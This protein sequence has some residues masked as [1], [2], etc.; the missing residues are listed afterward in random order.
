MQRRQASTLASAEDEIT[1]LKD[2]VH[3][4]AAQ[5]ETAKAELVAVTEQFGQEQKRAARTGDDIARLLQ[6]CARM[7]MRVPAR[8]CLRA[9]VCVPARGCMCSVCVRVRAR[10]AADDLALAAA[11]REA[12]GACRL[13]S[14]AR[15][16]L[17]GVC[18]MLHGVWGTAAADRELTAPRRAAW[19][20]GEVATARPRRERCGDGRDSHAKRGQERRAG[21]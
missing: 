12:R 11:D 17:S 14:V 5:A 6:V 19:R 13:S 4:V 1:T 20:R 10:T 8:A 21:R 16:L 7:S 9:R 15:C 18:C 2:R 3:H